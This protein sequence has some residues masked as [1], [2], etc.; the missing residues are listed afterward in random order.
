MIVEYLDVDID[1]TLD[2][3]VDLEP[4]L[5]D[6]LEKL[7]QQI[8]PALAECPED[9]RRGLRGIRLLESNNPKY[10]IANTRIQ[11]EYL[12][13]ASCAVGSSQNCHRVLVKLELFLKGSEYQ[14]RY[15]VWYRVHY[16]STSMNVIDTL[17]H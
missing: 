7:K 6:F 16:V 1:V 5:A 12:P 11:V 3:N 13:E 17:T 9:D 15:Q 4:L 8:V 2:S 10:V 14:V